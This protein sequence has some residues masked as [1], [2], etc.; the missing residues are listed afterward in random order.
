MANEL[1]ESDDSEGGR[2]VRPPCRVQ[3]DLA[4]SEQVKV[5]D[6]EAGDHD[7]TETEKKQYPKHVG[8]QDLS[9]LLWKKKNGVTS[10]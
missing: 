9:R 4:C 3:K 6:D 5:I 1:V 10:C 8:G 7:D 2:S